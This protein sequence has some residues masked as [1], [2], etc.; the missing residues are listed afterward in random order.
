[1]PTIKQY[2]NN[3]RFHRKKA[4]LR[5]SDVARML[6]LS[7]TD[8]VS[9]WEN[10]FIDPNLENLLHLLVLYKASPQELL[11]EMWQTISTQIDASKDVVPLEAGSPVVV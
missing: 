3:L 4:G 5:Q 2:P 1:M 10:G 8:R 9:R 7:S 6:K 11:P